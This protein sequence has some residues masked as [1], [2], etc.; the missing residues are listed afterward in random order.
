MENKHNKAFLACEDQKGRDEWVNLI[1]SKNED[2]KSNDLKNTFQHH[3]QKEI[4]SDDEPSEN[5]ISNKSH[6]P[7]SALKTT[8]KKSLGE[9]LVY[10]YILLIPN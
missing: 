9:S 4:S 10:Y 5:N 8:S 7:I 1:N 3:L 2:L 6:E